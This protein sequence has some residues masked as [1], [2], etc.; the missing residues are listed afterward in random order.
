MATKMTPKDVKHANASDIL[1][2]K[3]NVKSSAQTDT[4]KMLMVVIYALAFK[5]LYVL[6]N[7]VIFV[8]LM[9]TKMTQMVV[10][11]VHV[12]RNVHHSNV[13]FFVQ[14]VIKQM[15]KDAIFVNVLKK[16][17]ISFVQTSHVIA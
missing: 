1:V 13:N 14:T 5:I 3:F 11:H 4:S 16:T 15:K 10:R 9:D 2:H 12:P 7:N 8:A 17:Q 6:T